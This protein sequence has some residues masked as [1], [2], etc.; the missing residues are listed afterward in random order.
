[1][2][3]IFS[4]DNKFISFFQDFFKKQYNFKDGLNRLHT[5]D[6]LCEQD[7]IY[8]TQIHIIG[9]DD[10]NSIFIKDFHTYLDYDIY[11]YSIYHEFIQTNIIQLFPNEKS[12]V[13]QKTPNLRISFPNA[14]AIGRHEE[15]I[16]SNIIGAHTDSDFGHHFTEVN[17]II[18]IT[19]M[20][21]SNSVYYEPFINSG[22]PFTDFLN[23][24]LKTN[25]F[26][27]A[28]LNKL[29]HYNKINNTG[30]T[31]LSLDFRVIPFSLYKTFETDFKNT[32]FELGKSYYKL[33][34]V[35]Q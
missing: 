30:F 27:I 5:L 12:L 11:F 6:N 24:R 3:R 9:K 25:E 26:F 14:T 18:P 16:N 13:I 34:D 7:K 22:L 4:I 10:R 21:E 1:M 19:E 8:N 32:K 28:K 33:M 15:N 31:R 20:F 23:L 29:I 2:I 17:F 35:R